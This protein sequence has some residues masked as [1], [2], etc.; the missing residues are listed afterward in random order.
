MDLRIYI[1]TLFDQ[2][3]GSLEIET[4]TVKSF[5]LPLVNPYAISFDRFVDEK[6]SLQFSTFTSSLIQLQVPMRNYSLHK[7]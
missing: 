3:H 7:V 4:I 1:Y 6:G 2:W 5:R